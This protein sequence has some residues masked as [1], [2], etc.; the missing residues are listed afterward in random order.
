MDLYRAIPAMTRDL[1]SPLLVVSSDKP[2][3]LRTFLT[4]FPTGEKQL[5]MGGIKSS[6]HLSVCL[7]TYMYGV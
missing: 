6:L 2:G 7:Q 5:K 3:V 4:R 1:G